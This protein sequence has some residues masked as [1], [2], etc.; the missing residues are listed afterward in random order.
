M[1]PTAAAT[2]SAAPTSKSLSPQPNNKPSLK[3]KR[4]D[5]DNESEEQPGSIDRTKPKQETGEQQQRTHKAAKH[6]LQTALKRVSPPLANNGQ[7]SKDK[8]TSKDVP[9]EDV[10]A[11]TNN[12]LLRTVKKESLNPRHLS[13]PPASHAVRRSILL[14]LHETMTRLNDLIRADT[15]SSKRA[16]VLSDDELVSRALD[17]EEKVAKENATV[18]SNVIKL[19]ITKL[20]KMTQRDWEQD[21]FSYLQPKGMVEASKN[22]ADPEAKI[23]TGLSSK[24]EITVLS[25]LT[26]PREGIEKLG[27]VTSVPTEEDVRQA[28]SGAD[29]AQG[30]EKCDRCSGR[31]QVFPG[32]REDGILAS[33]GECTYHYAKL[34]RPPKQKTDNIVG[35]KE[36]YYGCCNETV[37]TSAGCTKCQWHVFKVSEAKRLAAMQQYQSTPRQSDK[38]VFPPVCFDCEMGYTTFGLELIRLTAVTWPKAKKIIDVL[39]RPIGEI[40]DLNSRFSGVRPEHFANALPHGTGPKDKTQAPEDAPLEIVESPSAAREL[41]F[42]HLQPE[43]PLIAHSIENDLNACRIIHP[44][45]VDTAILYPHPGGLPIRFGLRVLAKKHLDR[46]IQT[47]GGTRGHDSMEDARATADLVRLKVGETWK[48]LKRSDWE[49]KGGELVAP[50]TSAAGCKARVE[51]DKL[52]STTTVPKALGQRAGAKRKTGDEETEGNDTTTVS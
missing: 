32:R 41:L 1:P 33:G 18:Y 46:T 12:D 8:E 35:H 34:I 3:R 21:V 38:G 50:S 7:S 49:I 16:L 30:W 26:A 52:S 37:G 48:S 43:T 51:E 15:D 44:T 39:V 20:K 4:V 42:K 19:R 28:K 2:K 45:I 23:S 27:V 40:L 14:K 29:A 24:E 11:S 47:G 13:K 6:D 9:R 31:F 25:R 10:P 5:A 22:K 17:T 36:A